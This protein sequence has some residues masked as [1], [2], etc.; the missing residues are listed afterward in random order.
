MSRKYRHCTWA[1]RGHRRPSGARLIGQQSSG[2]VSTPNG[3]IHTRAAVLIFYA[4]AKSARSLGSILR[5]VLTETL[6]WH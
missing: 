4:D 2:L 3:I 5:G 1:Y 6:S